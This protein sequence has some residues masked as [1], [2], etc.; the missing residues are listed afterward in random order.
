MPHDASDSAHEC[1]MSDPVVRRLLAIGEQH[2][3]VWLPESSSHWPEIRFPK[4]I[5][6][7]VS[8]HAHPSPLK[9]DPP[10][11]VPHYFY[12]MLLSSRFVLGWRC[13]HEG[14]IDQEAPAGTEYD[15]F[16]YW[17]GDQAARGMLLIMAI[18]AGERT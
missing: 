15:D 6:Q 13:N 16:S 2:G 12:I 17:S 5:M 8:R 9:C 1:P 10:A 3:A 11:P 4:V 18:L 14:M 7:R